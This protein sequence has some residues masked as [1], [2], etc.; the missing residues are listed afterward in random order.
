MRGFCFSVL[1]ASCRTQIH[2]VTEKAVV[3]SLFV[4]QLKN[5]LVGLGGA[6]QPRGT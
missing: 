5:K 6:A 4:L 3:L 2:T 1:S